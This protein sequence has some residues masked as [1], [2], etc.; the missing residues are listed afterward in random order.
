MVY[1]VEVAYHYDGSEYWQGFV[2]KTQGWNRVNDPGL[3]RDWFGNFQKE[4]DGV[5][6]KGRWADCFTIISLPITH[7]VFPLILQRQLAK[8]LFDERMALTPQLLRKPD[9]LGARLASRSGGYSDRFRQFCENT[10]VLGLVALSLLVGADDASSYLSS[11]ALDRLVRGVESERQ[12]RSWLHS[13]RAASSRITSAGF[14]PTGGGLSGAKGT[15]LPQA[16]SPVLFLR[17]RE[18]LWEVCVELPDLRALAGS[19]PGMATALET[20]RA[21]LLGRPRPL[22]AGRLLDAGQWEL[23]D[24]WPTTTQPLVS[25]EGCDGRINNTLGDF[26]LKTPQGRGGFSLTVATALRPRFVAR[27]LEQAR[28]MSC[29]PQLRRHPLWTGSLQLTYARLVSRRTAPS[30]QRR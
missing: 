13:A 23:L 24:S 26:C 27:L 6:P 11:A 7:A 19:V 15:R 29:S 1:A 12:A 2:D 17:R 22:A 18:R 30:F 20:A 4:F 9:D 28:S 10:R 5:A 25:L 16:P 21:H 3:L 8:L 14:L